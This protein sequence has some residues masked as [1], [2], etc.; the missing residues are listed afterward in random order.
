MVN[1]INQIVNL[2][3]LVSGNIRSKVG[4]KGSKNLIKIK[5]QVICWKPYMSN[6]YSLVQ[7]KLIILLAL[8]K[9][10]CKLTKAD[11]SS[12]AT[13]QPCRVFGRDTYFS[14]SD[15]NAVLD[16]SSNGFCRQK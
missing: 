16:L 7:A 15:Q 12:R 4:N 9:P 10:G 3:R 5:Y 1:I 11:C 8:L 2:S 6:N 14:S 13:Q